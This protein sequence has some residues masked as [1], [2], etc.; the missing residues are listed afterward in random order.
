MLSKDVRKK[1]SDSKYSKRR[2]ER[3][4]EFEECKSVCICRSSLCQKVPRM[5]LAK[6]GRT[7]I[8]L[9]PM[10]HCELGL[11]CANCRG[12]GVA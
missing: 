6:P 4:H 9:S 2:A 7:S 3:E 12:P 5:R 10:K 1:A 8:S 11:A